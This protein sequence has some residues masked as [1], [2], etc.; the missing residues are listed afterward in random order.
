MGSLFRC[1]EVFIFKR[2][3]IQKKGPVGFVQVPDLPRLESTEGQICLLRPFYCS[4]QGR[5]SSCT[6]SLRIMFRHILSSIKSNSHRLAWNKQSVVVES[7]W[8]A[9]HCTGMGITGGGLWRCKVASRLHLEICAN[10]RLEVI[11]ACSL[12]MFI[13]NSQSKTLSALSIL[14]SEVRLPRS[15][16]CKRA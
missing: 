9:D 5:S 7:Y 16:I 1:V 13:D 3:H 8:H 14:Y 2:S 15:H 12:K 4:G 10:I 6:R 11:I